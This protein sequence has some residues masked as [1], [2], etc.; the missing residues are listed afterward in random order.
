MD[1]LLDSLS[2][3][4]KSNCCWNNSAI[5]QLVDQTFI[6]FENRLISLEVSE[7]YSPVHFVKER[8]AV[9][10]FKSM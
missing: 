1:V 6:N 8:S 5:N 4:I 2:L 3:A 7:I 9:L 10:A